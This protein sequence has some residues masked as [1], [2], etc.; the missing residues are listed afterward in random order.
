MC[1]SL[2][3][4]AGRWAAVPLLLTAALSHTVL[5]DQPAP[6]IRPATYDWQGPYAGALIGLKS[7]R[8]SHAD[9]SGTP[10]DFSASGRIAG[11]VAGY[12]FTYRDLVFGPE[13][14]FSYGL[15]KATR[16]GDGLKSDF[17]ATLRARLGRRF[18]RTLPYATAGLAAVHV[19]HKHPAQG[20][21]NDDILLSATAGAGIEFAFAHS[22]S[23]RVEYLYGHKLGRHGSEL[24]HT[25]V[26]RAAASYHFGRN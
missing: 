25:H 20:T 14:D 19:E 13:A 9:L 18:G 6:P 21:A 3:R 10:Q 5:A 11:I 24:D 2:I 1:S 23:A 7:F 4:S 12:N 8:T 26:I 22:L 16:N 17:Y 15:L